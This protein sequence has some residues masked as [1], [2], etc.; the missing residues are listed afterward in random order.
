MPAWE[1]IEGSLATPAGF[2]GAA[3]AAG[4]KKVEGSLDLALLVSDARE[5]SAAGTF[6]TNLAAAAPVI[7]AGRTSKRA[8]GEPAPS[9]STRATLTPARAAWGCAPPRRRREP[10]QN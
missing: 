6:T 7:L 4:I 5:T 2:R 9:S 10:P 1:R 3:V 8:A